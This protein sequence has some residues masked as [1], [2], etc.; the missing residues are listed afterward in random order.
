MEIDSAKDLRI[1]RAMAQADEP[2]GAPAPLTFAADLDDRAAPAAAADA[3]EDLEPEATRDPAERAAPWDAARLAPFEKI[4]ELR[5]TNAFAIQNWGRSGSTFAQSLF[6]DHPQVVSTPNFYSRGF[7]MAWARRIARTPDDRKLDIF[8]EVF[9]QWWDTGLVDATAG[10]HRLG[11]GRNELAGVPRERLEGYLRAAFATGRPITRQSLFE[12]GHLAYALARGQ[13]LAGGSLQVLY[14]IHGEPRAVACALLEDFPRARF[15]HTLREPVA[16]VASA[17]QH[18][19]F[20]NYD[21]RGDA[22]EAV[23]GGLFAQSGNRY[24]WPYTVCSVRPY[25]PYL[26]TRDQARFLR[27]EGLHRGGASAMS[28]AASWLEL[29]DEPCLGTS[30]WDGKVWWNRPES[31]RESRLGGPASTRNLERLSV[32]DRAK[33]RRLAQTD[34]WLAAAYPDADPS[35]LPNPLQVVLSTWRQ[36][37]IART[38]QLPS[39]TAL[40]ALFRWAPA[41]LTREL[42]AAIR[43]EHRRVRMMVM[44]SGAVAVRRTLAEPRRSASVRALL[45]APPGSAGR[46]RAVVKLDADAEQPDRLNVIVLDETAFVPSARRHVIMAAA[47]ILGWPLSRAAAFLRVRGLLA[48]L[49]FAQQAPPQPRLKDLDDATEVPIPIRDNNNVL[50]SA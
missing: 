47:L 19:C 5:V 18:H 20:N 14:P 11:E 40:R 38:A 42:E 46:V 30:T 29:A 49:V 26:A 35:R 27:L 8:L 25:L 28:R 37:G 10:L 7:Y 43:A 16:N 12:A 33:V 9:R 24:G 39:L 45:L 23:L 36:E 44:N 31:G 15:I 50:M 22:L 4:R 32:A 34:P 6:D 13:H 48:R 41:A 21:L 3:P 17:I 1:A 2:E